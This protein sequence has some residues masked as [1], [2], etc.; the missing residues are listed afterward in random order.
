MKKPKSAKAKNKVIIGL[1][2]SFASGKTTV[3]SCF[4][5][6]GAQIIDADKIAHN[7]IKRG[8]GVYNKIVRGFGAGILSPAGSIDRSKL[9]EA[10][11]NEKR[12][13]NKLNR[14]VHPEVIRR[15]K[16]LVKF[17]N[18]QCLVIDA[19]LLIETGLNKYCDVMVVVK[20]SRKKQ[21]ERAQK[22]SGLSGN[23]C[24]KRIRSQISVSRKVRLAD[25]VIDNNGSLEETEEQVRKIWK[26]II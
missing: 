3:S 8:S 13:L 18:K 19:P 7:A 9:G 24:L 21:I 14:L 1:T 10:V 22:K 6:L 11:F 25:F 26:K 15:V 17:S 16:Q 20:V 12:L 23:D 5:K 4:R 2:G